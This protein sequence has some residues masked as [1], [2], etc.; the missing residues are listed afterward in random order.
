MFRLINVLFHDKHIVEF[1]K[2]GECSLLLVPSPSCFLVTSF[3]FA[4]HHHSSMSSTSSLFI[5]D[6]L[7][8]YD[9]DTRKIGLDRNTLF[10]KMVH[11]DF[12]DRLIFEFDAILAADHIAFDGIDATVIVEHAVLK[13]ES[14]WKELKGRF[15][16]A[17]AKFTQSGTADHDFWNFSDGQADVFY[18]WTMLQTRQEAISFVDGGM[19]DDDCFDSM[20]SPTT[21][22][23]TPNDNT[24]KSFE[25]A[26][27]SGSRGSSNRTKKLKTEENKNREDIRQA[28]H[29]SADSNKAAA[30]DTIQNQ[31]QSRVLH[32]MELE[33][34]L[35]ESLEQVMISLDRL[36]G[37]LQNEKDKDEILEIEDT[38]EFYKQK[39]KK[40]KA[41][42]C[43]YDDMISES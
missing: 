28:I 38:I 43:S 20:I 1:M 6:S 10:W 26:E 22:A 27:S 5:G 14:M 32:K 18:L 25:D 41:E 23:T 31:E 4:P 2:T 36:R 16:K 12:I 33:K 37:K 8:K 39:R 40:I 13:L 11:E 3:T 19:L 17:K 24:R 21:T 7:T 15:K 34:R 9:L 29:I 30:L 35:M 42:L